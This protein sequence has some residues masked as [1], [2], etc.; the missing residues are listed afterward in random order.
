MGPPWVATTLQSLGGP[1]TLR[2]PLNLFPAS[3]PTC[4]ACEWPLSNP[5]PFSIRLLVL[6]T[7][8]L[9]TMSKLLLPA[10]FCSLGH[11]EMEDQDS[12]GSLTAHVP[13]SAS[14]ASQCPP[15]SKWRPRALVKE[16]EGTNGGQ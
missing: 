12:G 15:S 11:L 4:V 9:L 1:Y 13:H 10:V 7:G 6:F 5:F 3:T 8:Q 16:R 14:N 2:K